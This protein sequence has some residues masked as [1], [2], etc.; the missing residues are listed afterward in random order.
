MNIKAVVVVTDDDIKWLEIKINTKIEE[1]EKYVG[2]KIEDVKVSGTDHPSK[3]LCGIIFYS[4]K[5]KE[6]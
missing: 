3:V 4:I 2:Y 6:E 5:D 1:L